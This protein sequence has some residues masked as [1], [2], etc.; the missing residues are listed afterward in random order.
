MPERKSA[1]HGKLPPRCALIGREREAVINSW[2]G[3]EG[4]CPV[5]PIWQRAVTKASRRARCDRFRVGHALVAGGVLVKRRELLIVLGGVAVAW[6]L[7]TRA[8]QKP[9]PVVGVFTSGS[10]LTSDIAA[11]PP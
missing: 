11:L 2:H 8:Q 4:S 7:A 1:R 10:P 9:V 6:P 5:D 3:R